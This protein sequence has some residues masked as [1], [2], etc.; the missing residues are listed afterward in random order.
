[1]TELVAAPGGTAE[2][3][4]A[5]AV[6]DRGDEPA[7]IEVID[8]TGTE[9]AGSVTDTTDLPGGSGMPPS[10]A[11]SADGEWLAYTG[12]SQTVDA[13]V[14]VYVVRIDAVDATLDP[15]RAV[16]VHTITAP[17]APDTLRGL[18]GWVGPTSPE[19]AVSHLFVATAEGVEELVL[20]RADTGSGSPDSP[21]A[22]GFLEA[23]RVDLDGGEAEGVASGRV[24]DVSHTHLDADLAPAHR[25][26]VREDGEL[27]LA[28]DGTASVVGK[29]FA[30]ATRSASTHAGRT[31]LLVG[32]G[33]AFIVRYPEAGARAGTGAGT[34][35]RR[36]RRRGHRRCPPRRGGALPV[37]T[38]RRR[39]VGRGGP[40]PGRRSARR[41]PGG[42]ERLD[43]LARAA[44]RCC[45]RSWSP[46]R[47]RGR[48]RSSTSPSARDPRPTT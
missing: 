3:F 40:G 36:S 22:Q 10:I 15:A 14:A 24:V 46:S 5:V 41:R 17:D 11:I 37:P 23:E 29:R 30:P 13:A 21:R 27:E 12:I 33:R 35:G 25:L 47:R 44:R 34:R 26:T 32:E 42:R 48:A 38:P 9:P 1:V 39:E 28:F 8:R 19:G 31:A 4:R 18:L 45:S 6:Q 20:E 2:R 43:G 16:E 7:T